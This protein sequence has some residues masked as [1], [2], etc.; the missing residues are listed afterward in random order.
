[1]RFAL[2]LAS[3]P[4]DLT[5]F[6]PLGLASLG[7]FIRQSMPDVSVSIFEDAKSLIRSRPDVVGI[8]CSSPNF[9]LARRIARTVKKSLDVPVILGG[10]H[11]SCCPQSLPGEMDIGVLGEGEQTTAELLYALMSDQSD[12]S[13][14][15][16][17]CYREGERIH[18]TASREP[19]SDLDDLP[20]PARDLFPKAK[21][22]AHLVTSRGCPYTCSFC[23]ARRMW[24]DFRAHS[25]RRVLQEIETLVLHEGVSKIHIFDDL[26]VADRARFER[27]SQ[28]YA[29]SGLADRVTLSL[30]VRANLVDD[31]LGDLLALCTVSEVTFGAESPDDAV[32]EKIKPGLR[33]A[34]NERA[35]KILAS[36]GIGANVSMI[37][38]LPDQSAE[39]MRKTYRFLVR[40]AVAGRLQGAEVHVLAPYPGTP[41]FD[42]VAASGRSDTDFDW[43]RLARPW[44]GLVLNNALHAVASELVGYDRSLRRAFAKLHQPVLAIMS[45]VR[46]ETSLRA[47]CGLYPFRAVYA[48]TGTGDNQVFQRGTTDLARL[49]CESIRKLIGRLDAPVFHLPPHF[50]TLGASDFR[51]ALIAFAAG[52]DDPIRFSNGM[53]L[54]TGVRLAQMDWEK[55][56]GF[57][58]CAWPTLPTSE[59]DWLALVARRTEPAGDVVE[60]LDRHAAWIRQH[61][62]QD[63]GTD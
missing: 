18:I 4:H 14:I 44:D 48:A 26:F 29:Q 57:E 20:P 46:D 62:K 6:R 63:S 16:G 41:Y 34:D 40:H 60:L 3:G 2:I 17:L 52:D 35:L 45:G 19:I 8:S 39:S 31:A 51:A 37:V 54:A 25:A 30:A 49:D 11:I 33:A 27:F 55:N 38:G 56:D 24:G 28:R 15:P 42:D 13:D 9:N 10:V 43:S 61:L 12:L 47:V 21:G 1:M 58:L 50:D 22:Q 7:A 32:L 5:Q 23:S 36:R 59:P 53:R